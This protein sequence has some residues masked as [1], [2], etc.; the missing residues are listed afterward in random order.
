[1]ERNGNLDGLGD[2]VLKFSKHG[3]I[4]LG[5]DILGIGGVQTS[6]QSTQGS[7]THAFADAK[8]G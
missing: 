5:L 4:V 2:E 8:N 7:D 1:L 6:D 3:E